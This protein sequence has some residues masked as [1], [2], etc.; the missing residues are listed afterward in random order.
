MAKTNDTKF[1]AKEKYK[2]PEFEM[3]KGEYLICPECYSVYFRGSWH[4]ALSGDK[5]LKENKNL[6][7]TIC[8][9]DKMIKAKQFE[10]QLLLEGVPAEIKKD[11][12]NLVENTG[13][14]A[15]K[16]D[17]MDR[18]ISIKDKNGQVE[19]L[20]TE[21]QLAQRIAGKIKESFKNKM[22]SGW[23]I[24][25]SHGEDPVRITWKNK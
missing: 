19:I 3:A 22:R 13:G 18:I 15:F 5:D 25:H 10:G 23:K 4:H 14:M 24:I 7:F 2:K 12:F 20:T 8:P 11:L 9:A 16:K 17:P 1:P 6:K 21:N